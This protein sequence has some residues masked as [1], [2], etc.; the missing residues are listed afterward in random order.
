MDEEGDGEGLS[1]LN[2]LEEERTPKC[3]HLCTGE[4]RF[5]DAPQLLQ[6]TND[7]CKDETR[8]AHYVPQTSLHPQVRLST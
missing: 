6:H 2:K 3:S 7:L 5:S 4:Y 8:D 1:I